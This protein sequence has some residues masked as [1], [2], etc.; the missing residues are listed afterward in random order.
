MKTPWKRSLL[1]ALAVS[2]VASGAAAFAQNVAWTPLVSKEFQFSVSFCSVPKKDQTKVDRQ[3]GVVA[4]FNVF[5]GVTK[6]YVC[7]VSLADYSV[8]PDV[9]QELKLNQTN[10]VNPIKGTLRTSHRT[11]FIYRGEK[12]PA[13]TFSYDAR[14]DLAGKATVIVKGRRV[15]MLI[16]QYHKNRDYSLDV[17]KFLDSFQITN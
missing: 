7:A 8:T 16:F 6:N 9:E 11:D 14:P 4:T 2:C 13:L 3:K 12:L 17:Q 5:S 15:Y 1:K 10:L